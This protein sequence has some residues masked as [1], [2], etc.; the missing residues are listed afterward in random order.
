MKILFIT[1]SYPPIIGGMEEVSYQLASNLGQ[2]APTYVI[3]NKRGKKF[4]PFFLPWALIRG[5]ISVKLDGIKAIHLG[6]G[7]LTPLGAAIKSICKVPVTVTVHGLDVVYPNKIYQH[8]ITRSL[9][10]MDHIIAV[11][12]NTLNECLKRGVGRQKCSLIPNGVDPDKF[13]TGMAKKQLR[14]ELNKDIGIDL[15]DKKILISVGHL[16]KRKGFD[17]FIENA[18]PR[19]D[20]NTLYFVIG[21]YGHQSQGNEMEKIN[22][23]I[24]KLKLEKRVFLM[25]RVSNEQLKTFYNA[26][27]LLI[28][29]NIKVKGDV[30]GFGVTIL[31][32][33]SCGLPTIAS[34]VDG[35]KDALEDGQNG[36]LVQSE[37]SDSFLA[38]INELLNTPQLKLR[39]GKKAKK[40]VKNY[41]WKKIAFLYLETMK[42]TR[43]N[44]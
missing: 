15:R 26:A 8:L 32:A 30:E 25:G 40:Y 1:R 37:D 9:Y 5:L 6:D 35:I 42:S 12:Q 24:K 13:K 31:E 39:L 28:M 4:L 7:L 38:K 21:G 43:F 29:P 33:A 19:L 20:K 41:N 27:D 3:A 14:Q 11:S 17:W 44:Q 18:L 16:V 22:Q 23:L 2:L 10:K 36:F 34:D